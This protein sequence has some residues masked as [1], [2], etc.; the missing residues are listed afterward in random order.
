MVPV[1][2]LMRWGCEAIDTI[3]EVASLG[4]LAPSQCVVSVIFDRTFPDIFAV[5]L[6]CQGIRE[7]REAQRYTLQRYNCYFFAWAIVV[8]VCRQFTERARTSIFWVDK[9]GEVLIQVSQIVSLQKM[10]LSMLIFNDFNRC[11]EC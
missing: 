11:V 2:T 5:L 7:D 9:F 8:L 1:D 4:D 10:I 3:E 6:V